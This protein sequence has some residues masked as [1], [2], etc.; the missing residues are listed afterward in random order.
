MKIVIGI[1]IGILGAGLSEKKMNR[2]SFSHIEQSQF[3]IQ[4]HKIFSKLE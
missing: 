2:D 4:L 1:D 3:S